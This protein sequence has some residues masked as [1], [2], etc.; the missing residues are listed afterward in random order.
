MLDYTQY[1]LKMREKLAESISNILNPFLL[2]VAVII[3]L[4]VKSE[5]SV[6]EAVKWALIA[7]AMSVL[8]IFIVVICLVRQKKLEGVFVNPRNQR[9]GIYVLS[10][11]LGAIAC[12]VMW[13]LNAPRLLSV[14]FT[15]GLAAIVVFMIINR[16][17]K[18]SLH[19]AFT[20][21]SV[22]IITIVYGSLGAFTI[23]LLPPVAW[24]RIK[25]KQHSPAQVTTGALL[26]AAI[27]VM[28]FWGFDVM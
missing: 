5:L 11:T 22:T 19:T 4:A 27:V 12:G 7:I 25:L 28:V 8:P 21:A 20:S 17:W 16:F 13:Y 18:I 24:S 15:A 1:W 9:N 3:L 10:S 6:S 23:L 14:T 26:S 2:S